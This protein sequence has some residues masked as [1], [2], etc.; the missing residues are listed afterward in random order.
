MEGSPGLAPGPPPPSPVLHVRGLPEDATEAELLGLGQRFGPV[1]K[2]MVMTGKGQGFVEYATR[3]A[4]AWALHAATATSAPDQRSLR[5]VP[6]GWR[7]G[8]GRGGEGPR[9]LAGS[10]LLPGAD[11][12]IARVQGA[13]SHLPGLYAPGCHQSRRCAAYGESSTP[14]DITP[15]SLTRLWLRR[16]VAQRP[17]NAILLITVTNVLYPVTVRQ[18]P[19]RSPL[20]S[21]RRLSGHRSEWASAA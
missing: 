13:A 14:A 17:A 15:A 16:R 9:A 6:Q 19:R 11:P 1:D 8:V 3:E 5:C 4:A 21:G 20:D 10:A 12:P 18:L 7:V 2:V